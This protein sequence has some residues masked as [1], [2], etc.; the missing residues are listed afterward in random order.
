MIELHANRVYQSLSKYILAFT[1]RFH[2]CS[3]SLNLKNVYFKISITIFN[4]LPFF[5]I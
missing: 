5:I 3:N 2:V 4:K 1:G